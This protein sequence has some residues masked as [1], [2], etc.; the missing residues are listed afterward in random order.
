MAEPPM[1]LLR[2][3]YART[4]SETA[5]K[6]VCFIAGC[7][8]EAVGDVTVWPQPPGALKGN[9]PPVAKVVP[10]CAEHLEAAQVKSDDFFKEHPLKTAL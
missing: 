2:P 1:K 8:K 9:E 6:T 7:D 3:P 5:A 4:M 10:L